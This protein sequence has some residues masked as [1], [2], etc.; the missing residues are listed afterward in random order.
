MPVTWRKS[1]NDYSIIVWKSTEPI[2]ALL[3]NASLNHN[4]IS[5][6]NSFQSHSRKREWLTVRSALQILLPGA[7]SSTIYYDGNGKPHLKEDGF[8]SISHSHEYIAVMKSN[9]SE[10]KITNRC[11]IEESNQDFY[12]MISRIFLQIHVFKSSSRT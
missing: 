9:F 10:L 11:K 4:E 5:E 1:T 3:Q 8:I 12:K 6:W 7:N 2:E